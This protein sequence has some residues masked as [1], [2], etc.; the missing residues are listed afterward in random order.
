[1]LQRP[2]IERVRHPSL[3][4]AR[5]QA[6]LVRACQLRQHPARRFLAHAIRE[7]SVNRRAIRDASAGSQL[8]HRD[9]YFTQ[10]LRD[11]SVT[12]S[13]R[14]VAWR[15]RHLSK[16]SVAPGEEGSVASISITR[17][18]SYPSCVNTCV[19][20]CVFM[21]ICTHTQR[22]RECT[23]IHTQA[24]RLRACFRTP[25]LRVQARPPPA[26]LHTAG[27]GVCVCV[28]ACECECECECVNTCVR[29]CVSM[30]TCVH[31]ESTHTFTHIA[32]KPAGSGAWPCRQAQD[33]RALQFHFDSQDG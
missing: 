19:R 2:P 7:T 24:F 27:S 15:C 16:H 20:V 21:C 18:S 5:F 33:P 14:W 31:T 3:R 28:R 8:R 23:H 13:G 26:T 9:T 11:T 25:V 29:V 17:L 10:E 22:E 30:C 6:P 1:M 4:C 32:G 12:C